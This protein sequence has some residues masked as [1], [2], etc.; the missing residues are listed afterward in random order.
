MEEDHV[1]EEFEYVEVTYMGVE[2]GRWTHVCV[3]CG[4]E[5]DRVREEC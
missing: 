4:E 3:D 2:E 1:C 5:D